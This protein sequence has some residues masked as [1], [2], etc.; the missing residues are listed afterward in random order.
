M[1]GWH[2]SVL[3]TVENVIIMYSSIVLNTVLRESSLKFILIRFLVFWALIPIDLSQ[4][5]S[6]HVPENWLGI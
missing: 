5:P 3:L 1:Y 2:E 4:N 6:G